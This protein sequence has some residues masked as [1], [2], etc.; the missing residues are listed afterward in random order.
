MP[1]SEQDGLK[2]NLI[3][4]TCERKHLLFDQAAQGYD[5]FVC[6]DC[7]TVK[8]EKLK[9]LKCEK[10]CADTFSVM[11]EIEAEN[12]EQF[13]EECVMEYPDEFS[14]DDYVDVFNWIVVTVQCSECSNTEE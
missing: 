7:K 13:I 8:D 2:I 14:A 6:H 5:G 12:K 3:C 1:Y 4:Q 9:I 10:C 11:L